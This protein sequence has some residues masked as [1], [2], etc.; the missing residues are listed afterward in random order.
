MLESD[1][2]ES[3]LQLLFVTSMAEGDVLEEGDGIIEQMYKQEENLI[4]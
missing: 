2:F 1:N 3:K 4:N